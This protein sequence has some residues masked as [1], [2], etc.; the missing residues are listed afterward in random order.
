VTRASRFLTGLAGSLGTSL[1]GV[2][3]D[4]L[5]ALPARMLAAHAARA[6]T[7]GG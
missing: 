2:A 1:A 6:A 7:G 5:K 4:E 3:D